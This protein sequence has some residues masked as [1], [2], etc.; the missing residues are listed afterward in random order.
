[1]LTTP[2]LWRYSLLNYLSYHLR[3][4]MLSFWL[5]SVW[6]VCWWCTIHYFCKTAAAV[7]HQCMQILLQTSL[8]WCCMKGPMTVVL[9]IV[10]IIATNSK[11]HFT[12]MCP[13]KAGS[14]S[15]SGLWLEDFTW[16]GF[17]RPDALPV[18]NHLACSSWCRR[19]WAWL[20]AAIGRSLAAPRFCK[21][22]YGWQGRVRL[23]GYGILRQSLI[24]LLTTVNVA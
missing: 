1:M 10:P 18:A 19:K 12:S 13:A 22:T 21:P 16:C 11:H 3:I 17:L 15:A 2:L 9:Q 7:L 23:G 6:T 5:P 4:L 8:A 20:A 24:P 14:D